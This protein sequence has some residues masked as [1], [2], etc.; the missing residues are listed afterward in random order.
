MESNWAC[1]AARLTM[2]Y[3]PPRLSARKKVQLMVIVTI[4]AWATQTLFHQWGHGS[5]RAGGISWIAP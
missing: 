4:L 5:D 3:P 2:N 1:R